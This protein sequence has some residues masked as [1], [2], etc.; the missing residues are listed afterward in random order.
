MVANQGLRA[1]T[2]DSFKRG[3]RKKGY[4]PLTTY[5][6][7]YKL[8]D[9]VDVVVNG[10]VQKVRA[11]YGSRPRWVAP[12]MRDCFPGGGRAHAR[13]RR[14]PSE[15]AIEPRRCARAPACRAT[16]AAWVLRAR[17][18]RVGDARR[19]SGARLRS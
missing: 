19:L 2:R 14:G 17:R 7:N 8:G 15:R 3:Y 6:T 9:F 1:G 12:A 4:I 11:A 18:R 13:W 16:E 5:L 10:A